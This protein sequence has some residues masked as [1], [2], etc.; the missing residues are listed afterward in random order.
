MAKT[1]AVAGKGGTGKTTVAALA[2]RYITETLGHCVM[3]VDADP[4]AT[5]GFA[6]G[7]EAETTVAQIREDVVERRIQV[8]PGMSRE[9]VVEYL[10]HQSVLECGPFDLL[11]MGRP[12]GPK[13]Y[14][15]ANHI[16][17]RYLDQAGGGYPFMVIDNE[18]GMEHLSRRT[19]NDVDLL[20]A[21]AEPTVVSVR[22]AA[23][24][25]ETSR[26][27][28]ITVRA[29]GLVI[30]QLRGE[31]SPRAKADV[32]AVGW[33]VLARIPWDEAVAAASAEGQTVLDLPA[34]NPA[35]QAVGRMLSDWL[36]ETAPAA[37]SGRDE[38]Q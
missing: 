28:P 11:T 16:L 34:D 9:R 30:N 15:A 14:C 3:A 31:L 38:T 35:Y 33:P 37:H 21:V 7:V 8:S 10:V 18:A 25:A 6:L 20:L 26:E 36:D 22:S 23:R 32:D 12:E 27:L 4:N 1:L 24:V 13:C 29:G 17:R 5:L 19:T 2:V